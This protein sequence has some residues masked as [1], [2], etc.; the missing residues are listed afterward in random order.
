[1]AKQQFKLSK[2]TQQILIG[3]VILIVV[4]YFVKKY[5]TN[6]EESG[7]TEGSTSSTSTSSSS[8]YVAP[9]DPGNVTIKEGSSG[10]PVKLTQQRL[11]LLIDLCKAA[12]NSQK[13]FPNMSP[14]TVTRINAIAVWTKLSVDGKFGSKTKSL[15][16][17]VTGS[18]TTTLNKVRQKYSDFE[19]A[20]NS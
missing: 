17:Y 9:V 11:N 3:V 4:I 13:A 18:S 16:T 12:Y 1:M 6:S 10:E 14:S 8:A 20:I 15:V 5:R 7:N 19:T 2:E